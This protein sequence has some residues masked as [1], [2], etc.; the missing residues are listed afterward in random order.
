MKWHSSSPDTLY[1][2]SVDKII[3]IGLHK[4]KNNLD[5]DIHKLCFWII[6]I[7]CH[8]FKLFY[9]M[10]RLKSCYINCKYRAAKSKMIYFSVKKYIKRD[11]FYKINIGSYLWRTAVKF[12]NS[13]FTPTNGCNGQI[14]SRIGGQY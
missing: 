6:E 2:G 4:S 12:D 11:L 13:L 5:G 7:Y 14:V 3:I 9:Y 10:F 1:N 8:Q